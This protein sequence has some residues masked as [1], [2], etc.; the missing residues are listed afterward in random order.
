VID[1]R[2]LL[3]AAAGA[4]VRPGDRELIGALLRRARR[5][6]ALY[7]AGLDEADLTGEP[8]HLVA[9]FR[10]QC[11]DH[12]DELTFVYVRLGGR[13]PSDASPAPKPPRRRA[14]LRLAARREAAAVRGCLEA[15]PE[16]HNERVR[17]RLGPIMASHAQHLALLRELIGDDPIPFAF[18]Q[19]RVR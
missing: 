19:G 1:R 7:A 15:L 18:E 17:R 4:P 12:V 5:L 13:P 11:A 2:G 3:L 16:I 14:F 10:N 8:R 9:T 6:E